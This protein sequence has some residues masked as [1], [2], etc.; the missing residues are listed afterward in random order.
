VKSSNNS[1]ATLEFDVEKKMARDW[2]KNEGLLRSMAKNIYIYIYVLVRLEGLGQLKNPMTP[3]G[4]EPTTFFFF[5]W[6]V[7]LLAL[8]PRLAY[9]A[10]LG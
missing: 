10:S 9:C 6:F 4:F 2:T 7:R 1:A 3:L 5:I 8:R